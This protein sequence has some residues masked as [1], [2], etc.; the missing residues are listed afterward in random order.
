[1]EAKAHLIDYYYR[2]R[3][4]K[5][6]IFTCLFLAL[7]ITGLYSFTMKP[8][9]LAS[10]AL[11]IED[12]RQQSPLTGE[13]I[14]GESQ[15]SQY[16]TFQ[17]HFKMITSKP[18][19]ERVLQRTKIS[20]ESL[21]SGPIWR[22]LETIRLNLRRVVYGAIEAFTPG[23]RPKQPA[24]SAEE[25]ALAGRVM[26]LSRKIGIDQVR[27][28]R[29]LRVE[30]ED[31]DPRTARDLANAVAETY[32]LY[33][34]EVRLANSRTMMTWLNNQLYE[35]RKNVEDAERQFLAFKEKENLFS[36]EGKQK[37][38]VQKIEEMNA[39]YLQ[40]RS[41]RLEIEAKIE[42]LQK[43][44]ERSKGASVEN[45]PAFLKSQ[46]LETL[47]SDLLKAEVEYRKLKGVYKEKHPEMTKL[48]SEIQGLRSKIVQQVE[49]AMINS[50]AERAVL[51]AREKAL[52]EAR[53]RYETDAIKTNRKEMEYS[54]LEREVDTSRELYNTLLS[55]IKE[56]NILGEITSS[57]LRF[58][59]RASTPVWPARPKKILNMV[60]AFISGTLAGLGLALLLEYLDQ[61]VHN[62]EQV[63]KS[64]KLSVLS[65]IPLEKDGRGHGQLKGGYISPNVLERPMNSHFTESF[66]VLTTG[67]RFSRLNRER[68]VYLL[69]S[70]SPSEGKSTTAFNLG[71]T[72]SLQGMRTILVEADLR[73]P[74]SRK[75]KGLGDRPGVADILTETFST[76]VGEGT[77]GELTVGDIH[78]LLEIQEKTGVVRY[79]NDEHTFTVSFL[80][81]HII[82]VDWPTRPPEERLGTLLVRSG[83]ITREQA[84]I[85][86]SKQ[87]T[88]S[89]R[90]GQVLIHLGFLGIDRLAGPLKLQM[91]ENLKALHSCQDA[92]YS[93]SERELG[94]VLTST[95]AKEAALIEAIGRVDSVGQVRTPFL[96]QQVKNHLLQISG[97][98][99][100]VLTAGK[101]LPNPSALLTSGRMRVLVD[102][103]RSEFDVV[104]LDSP[105]AAAISDPAALA[106]LCDGVILVVRLGVTHMSEVKR[107]Q[108][109]L[110]AV[111]APIVGTVLN[112]LEI[113]K[114]PYYY[115]RY[116]HKYNDYYVKSGKSSRK[117]RASAKAQSAPR[118]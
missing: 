25:K 63:E 17:T 28:T 57:N 116:Y 13:S 79:W 95:D 61:T 102:M 24:V 104:L 22:F 19:L 9:Y 80:R 45:I 89:G 66:R 32:I 39:S 50:R 49:K 23:V 82:D 8:V 68:G 98:Q 7:V 108:E 42:E 56:T 65:E 100:W 86:L 81:G 73:L 47:F 117:R 11:V 62:R 87:K 14:G 83:L 58:V 111:Q 92:H 16:M 33:D 5:G 60:V 31:T 2:L 29:L 103:L 70:A 115:S 3:R 4:R 51:I 88:T 113:K 101:V 96:T 20:D 91:Q 52:E 30:V 71:L 59:E 84:S 55:R 35:M 43:Y 64:L 78:R 99:M 77:L 93:F 6:V 41:Q 112:A 75:V 72:M 114:E 27:N 67:L 36:I 69:T 44:I 40:I 18:V 37:I 90:L 53:D 12:E 110:E 15:F 10:A 74:T 106:Q 94:P 97:E 105:P 1:M 118:E 109:Q 54:I 21:Q 46:L 76:Q 26:A 34:S 107:A 48:V 85:A 38:G